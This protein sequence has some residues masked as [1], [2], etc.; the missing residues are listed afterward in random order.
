M[1]TPLLEIRL[2]GA[3]GAW[4]E[5]QPLPPLRSR[6][7]KWLLALLALR[8]GGAVSREWLSATLWPNSNTAMALYNLRR[9]LTNLRGA[10]GAETNL[11]LAPTPKTLCLDRANVRVDVADFDAAIAAGGIEDLEQAAALYRGP[12]LE[13]CTE[14]WVLSERIEREHTYL[15]ALATL[16]AHWACVNQPAAAVRCLR[17]V[18]AADPLREANHATL[19]QALADC[20]DYAA[21][22]QVYRDLRLLLHQE[23]NIAASAETDALYRRLRQQA[24]QVALR[25]SAPRALPHRR[26]PVPL[27]NLV[28]R[29]A[30]IAQ[31][32]DCLRNG[33]MVTLL[34]SGGIGKTRLAIAA[35]EALAPD[36]PDG[37]WFVEMTSLTD[38]ALVVQTV[39]RAL[40][41]KEAASRPLVE[42]LA[43]KVASRSLLLI[44]D[45]CEHLRDACATLA[46][47]LLSRCSAL[48]LLATSRE[49]LAIVG[50]F[51]YHTPSLAL[52]P[53]ASPNH[54]SGSGE[55]D[56]AWLME[57]GGMRL[58]VERAMQ[59]RPSFRLTTRNVASVLRVVRRLDGIPLAIELAAARMG[60]LSIAEIQTRLQDC[61]AFLES[62]HRTAV[63][64]HQTLRALIDWSYDLLNAREKALLQRLSV[65]AGGWTLEAAE[66]VTSEPDSV[67]SANDADLRRANPT[68]EDPD[69]AV[70]PQCTFQNPKSKIQN[71]AVLDPLTAL[72]DKSLVMFE[73][74]QGEAHYRL[75]ETMRQYAGD[76]LAESGEAE[77]YRSRHRDYFL[78]LAEDA[79]EK[80]TG[81]EQGLWLDRLET[82]HDNL[83]QALT[84]CAEG[85]NGSDEGLR[86]GAAL[87]HF[88]YTRGYLREGRDRLTALLERSEA[89]Q[90][91]KA[92]AEVLT[93]VASLC[94]RQGE[95]SAAQVMH[96]KSLVIMRKLGDRRGVA[97]SIANLG[98]L[99][100]RRG[101]Y[102]TA[103]SMH[104]ESL[105]I[106]RDLGDRHSIAYSLSNLGTLAYYQGDYA[107]ADSLHQE[108]LQINRESGDRWWIAITLQNLGLVACDQGDYAKSQSLHEESLAIR[109]DLG[110]RW[111]IAMSLR[112]LGLVARNQGD[113]VR[114]RSLLEE[115]LAI[116]RELGDR[117]AI[118]LALGDL[119]SAAYGQ[120]DGVKARS[121][122]EESLA[123]RRELGDRWGMAMSL[124]NLGLVACDVGDYVTAR[125]LL[126][127]SLEIRMQLGDRSGIALCLGNL[128]RLAYCQ[129][130]DASDRPA[131]EPGVDMRRE[132]ADNPGIRG[133]LEYLAGRRVVP[134]EYKQAARSWGAAER[135]RE[136]IGAPM[137]PIERHEHG[138]TVAEVRA[139]LGEIDFAAAWAEGRTMTLTRLF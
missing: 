45:N 124:G 10:L 74:Q 3:F 53:P 47:A 15:S 49:A 88:W 77:T 102:S 20:G 21:V 73:E 113:C 46:D 52:P 95:Y 121:L 4:L 14:E 1:D 134:A 139:A 110:D 99:A 105:A 50:E 7:E 89:R 17:L 28:G 13:T 93:G 126:N 72:V 122:Q 119:G 18:I 24:R 115:S 9:C 127:E 138:R 48:R 12:L 34:G 70:T 59:V 63:P 103:R 33:R 16:A 116:W 25:P 27:T 106:R 58:F 81:P 64:R 91:T 100:Y 8:P 125:S 108:S 39:A 78:A 118:S 114:A 5:G 71:P 35:A 80:L 132:L 111:G 41:V 83:R 67:S 120:G 26:L 82:E 44:L 60:S 96:E 23:L 54:P 98:L 85:P 130:R 57:Y 112:N 69:A 75:L 22:S 30:E 117:S 19:M 37:V 87:Q 40:G 11:L 135:L 109:K 107:S 38:P 36:C 68:R 62:G 84:F 94:H 2:F 66:H 101:D 97:Q 31:V 129:G 42:T 29:E 6:G 92:Y 137:P 55:K 43:A 56:P 51:R 61:F 86:M 104:Q 131:N 76:R 90:H 128:G 79:K 32:V 136:E 65:F 133:S 123:I